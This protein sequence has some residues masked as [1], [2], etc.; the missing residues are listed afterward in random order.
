MLCSYAL[1]LALNEDIV[2]QSHLLKLIHAIFLET[3]MMQ[4]GSCIGKLKVEA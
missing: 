4:F 1:A 3:L 2:L